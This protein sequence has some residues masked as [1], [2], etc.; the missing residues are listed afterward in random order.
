M[1]LYVCAGGSGEIVDSGPKS[2]QNGMMDGGHN[3]Y[4]GA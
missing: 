4:S 2:T 1:H 3:V